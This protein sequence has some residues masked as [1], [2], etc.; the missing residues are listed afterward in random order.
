MKRAGFVLLAGLAL[1]GCARRVTQSGAVPS[2]V[3]DLQIKNA[4]RMGEGN[5]E[6]RNLRADVLASPKD[7]A[8]RRRLAAR[9]LRDGHRDLAIEHLRIAAELTP[10]D[11]G[12]TL[13]L[14][15][16]LRAEGMA[17]EA[18]KSL[19]AYRLAYSATPSLLSLNA[20]AWDEAGELAKGETLHREAL[21]R[22]RSDLRLVNNLAYNLAQQKRAAEAEALYRQLLAEHPS[23][24]PA[25]NNLAELYA[26]Q[27]N[28]PQ[29]AL[30]HWKAASGP[31]NAHNNLAA[32]F[33]AQGRNEEA[34][35]ELEKA[36]AIRFQFPEAQRNL[37]ILAART[38][39]TIQL[40]LHRDK[41]ARGLAK[42]AKALRQVFVSE[43]PAHHGVA[44]R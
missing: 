24:E 43:E 8:L 14:A 13:E 12:L 22:H 2:S 6:L 9:F 26:T 28:Q 11:A 37:Q 40:D 17:E 33:I 18:A 7:V 5:E 25:R 36:L 23:F 10:S 39:G 31:A 44:K 32:A 34:R 27:L 20:I 21:A 15:Q 30:L 19:D 4:I 29:E 1:G 35:Q 3:W 42:L 38:S 16:L 41:E